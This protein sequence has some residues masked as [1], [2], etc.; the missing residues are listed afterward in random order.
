[1]K[2]NLKLITTETFGELQCNFYCNMN[3]NI[4]LTRE[5]IGTALEYANPSKAI[6]TIHLKHKDRIESLCTRI[7]E[8]RHPQNGGS[9]VDVETVYYTERGIMEICRWSRQPKANEFMDWVWDII[10][11][12]RNN[13]LISKSSQQVDMKPIADA[14]TYMSQAITTLTQNISTMQ[15]DI[16]ELKQSQQNRYLAEKRYP[17]AWYKKMAP[18]YKMLMEYFHCSRNELYSSIYK[19]LEDTYDV[20]INQIYED[21]CYENHLPKEECYQ[22]DAIEHNTKLRDALTLLIDS[23]LVKYGIQTEE[24]IKNFKRKTLFDREV[25]KEIN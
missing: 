14:I 17:S 15:Q 24:E 20:D 13:E 21:Y 25:V 16:Q 8:N 7:I 4:L 12:Y 19:E 6:Q 22:M 2:N 3:D 18:K 9:G 10:E 1:M 5:Q 23:S 11:A